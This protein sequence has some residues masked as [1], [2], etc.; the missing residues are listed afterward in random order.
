MN[1]SV[2]R[3]RFLHSGAVG[4]ASFVGALQMLQTRQAEAH[5]RPRPGNGYGPIAP[6]ND[7]TTGLPLLQ[8]PEASPTA[9]S[10]GPATR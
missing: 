3:R 7:L 10:A 4:A 1:A 5:G 6:V 8:L 9:L 2:S